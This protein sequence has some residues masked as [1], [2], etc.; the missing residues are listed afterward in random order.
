MPATYRH[1]S[2]YNHMDVTR[3]E[4]RALQNRA[5]RRGSMRPMSGVSRT[6]FCAWFPLKMG[7]VFP[8]MLC[9]PPDSSEALCKAA[10]CPFLLLHDVLQDSCIHND[11]ALQSKTQKRWKG[12]DMPKEHTDFCLK[13]D[14]S[15]YLRC[16]SRDSCSNSWAHILG[17]LGHSGSRAGLQCRDD[18]GQAI[19]ST[20]L[21][22]SCVTFCTE[23]VCRANS[24]PNDDI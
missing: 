9:L 5:P 2:H 1:Y 14:Y 6:S 8:E 10:A 12:W 19:S 16:T 17:A 7:Q 24:N 13:W 23:P 11:P 22:P 18:A 21:P 20:M 3:G 4:N 15:M